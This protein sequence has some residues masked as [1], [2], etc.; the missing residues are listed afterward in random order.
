MS[1]SCICYKHFT[2]EDII[3]HPSKWVLKNGVPLQFD[4]SN[5]QNRKRQFLRV[6]PNAAMAVQPNAV[7]EKISP[8]SKQTYLKVIKRRWCRPLTTRKIAHHRIHVKR[9]IRKI[10]Q[11]HIFYQKIPVCM[12]DGVLNELWLVCFSRSNHFRHCSI[13]H[14]FGNLLRLVCMEFKVIKCGD[15]W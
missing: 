2:D 4:W 6:V 14:C 7:W 8:S 3:N 9:P 13:K 10:K 1:Y 5:K 15:R 12:L 11:C